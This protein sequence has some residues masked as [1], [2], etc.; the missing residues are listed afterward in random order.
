MMRIPQLIRIRRE[1]GRDERLRRLGP[2]ALTMALVV[3][4]ALLVGA[5]SPSA[6]QRARA[7]ADATPSATGARIAR[8]DLHVETEKQGKDWEVNVALTQTENDCQAPLNGGI[9]LRYS[10]VVDEAAA[11]AGYGM[12]PASDV[13]VTPQTVTLRVDTR[14]TPGFSQ[15]IGSGLSISVT[16][17]AGRQVTTGGIP[18]GQMDA[19]LARTQPAATAQGDVGTFVIPSA[20][21]GT[22][23]VAN[24]LL[25]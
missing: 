24:M 6:R 20:G 5:G 2:V 22:D 16:W 23:L 25:Q 14:R 10:I 15:V 4:A 21:P 13:T 8:A 7:G 18:A 1:D 9:C 19:N 3:G 12:I 11:S 17:H